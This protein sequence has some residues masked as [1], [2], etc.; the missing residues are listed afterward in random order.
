M[1]LW[2][3]NLLLIL[4]FPAVLAILLSKARCRPGLPYRVGIR[5]PPMPPQAAGSGGVIWIHAVSLGEVVAVAPLAKA[6]Y[7][8][9]PKRVIVVSTVTETGR[10]AVLD[11]LAG[12]ATH[13]YAPLDYR[14]IVRMFVRT[15]R[16]AVYVFVETELW[17]NLLSVLQ[18][19]RV[20]TILVN[21]R[22]SSRSF[23]RQQWPLIRSVYRQLLE[24]IS[25]CLMQSERDAER[26][27]ALGARPDRVRKTGNIKFDQPLPA[28]SSA[29]LDPIRRWATHDPEALVVVAGSTH[30]GEEELLV[31]ACESLRGSFPH[32]RLVLAPRHIERTAEV[33]QALA[34]RGIPVQRRSQLTVESL[35]GHEAPW[36]MLL[37]T[38]GELGAVYQYATVAFVGGTL[39]PV[40]GHNLLEPAAWGKPVVFG[41]HTDH[42]QDIAR[43]LED[44][45]GGARVSDA[46]TLSVQLAAWLGDEERRRTAGRRAEET[47]RQNQGALD[48]CVSVIEAYL[49]RRT[50]PPASAGPARPKD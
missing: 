32:L 29:Q 5:P 11:R 8:R 43:L 2:G 33:A 16:P 27:I 50:A 47:V 36:L 15:L 30:P 39:V 13:C 21:G 9:D 31:Q 38:R 19:H 26:A 1:V 42:C 37:D 46:A 17:P 24:R 7:A 25:M 22:I 20:S 40:G 10:E 34:A 14:W 28:A 6:L 45:G 41:S 18:E 12:V 44:S 4:A 35:A 3:Y 23:A 48:E 49:D